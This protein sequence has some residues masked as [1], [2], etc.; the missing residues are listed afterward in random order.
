MNNFLIYQ[1]LP[2]SENSS[3]F[4]PVVPISPLPA[5][6]GIPGSFTPP[7]FVL[8]QSSQLMI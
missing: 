4:L 7:K 6:P 1:P 3:P 8:P 5:S 2:L